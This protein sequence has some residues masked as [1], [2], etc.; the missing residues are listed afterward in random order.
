MEWLDKLSSDTIR[1]EPFDKTASDKTALEIPVGDENRTLDVDEQLSA[2]LTRKKQILQSID[3]GEVV[4][5]ERDELT[6][7][8][9]EIDELLDY[10]SLVYKGT[11]AG[12]LRSYDRKAE[13]KETFWSEQSFEERFPT[14]A[15]YPNE[16]DKVIEAIKTGKNLHS[17]GVWEAITKSN[18]Q[19]MA[20][21]SD[22]YALTQEASE[23][24]KA[25][26]GEQHGDGYHAPTIIDQAA[27]DSVPWVGKSFRCPDYPQ[28]GVFEIKSVDNTRVHAVNLNSDFPDLFT[29]VADFK[30]ALDDGHIVWASRQLETSEEPCSSCQL[31]KRMRDSNSEERMCGNRQC[32][33]FGVKKKEADS[34]NPLDHR[35]P[36][37]IYQDPNLKTTSPHSEDPGMMPMAAD[38]T[39]APPTEPV[40]PPA[41]PAK[42]GMTPE[43]M[44]GVVNRRVELKQKLD[45][46]E[47][48]LAKLRTD[49]MSTLMPLQQQVKEEE[50]MLVDA[51]KK[52]DGMQATVG[53]WK[54]F[55][56]TRAGYDK[57]DKAK[58]LDK[59]T[60]VAK[61]EDQRIF[62]LI[63]QLSA[64]KAYLTSVKPSQTLQ[65]DRVKS[66]QLFPE[67]APEEPKQSTKEWWSRIKSW[68]SRTFLPSLEE[69]ETGMGEMQDYLAYA[70]Q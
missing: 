13:D 23:W 15:K 37:E 55:I 57:L 31:P 40:A 10:R 46:L 4:S 7:L 53:N 44:E 24:V 60:E 9:R 21:N 70:Q 58:L 8:N 18:F 35:D 22:Y 38:E 47:D 45:E 63:R 56:K 39:Q 5:G 66:E 20:N 51:L 48:H 27:A 68:F 59:I 14:M 25:N 28:K 65:V 42:P 61:E 67:A 17:L 36:N 50:P 64:T 32:P 54:A 16:A 6:E 26:S 52:I 62:N 12:A 41:E 33:N 49:A 3:S 1:K 2:A 19:L 43:E 29:L 30:H 69:A 11:P 34:Q